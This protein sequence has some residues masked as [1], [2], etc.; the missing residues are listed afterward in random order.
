[1]AMKLQSAIPKLPSRDLGI[2]KSFYTEQLNFRQVGG[3]F[4]DYL[5][6]IRDGIELHFFLHRQLDVLQNDAMCYIRVSG[7]EE[8][9]DSLKKLPAQF[10]RQ[11]LGARA[12]GQKEFSVIDHDH[13]LL[14]FGERI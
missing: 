3:E 11:K 12:W 6:L 14:T 2:T 4:P 8:L 10:L 9:F 5:M 1:M 7:I 13:N